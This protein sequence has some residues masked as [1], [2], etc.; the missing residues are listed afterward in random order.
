MHLSSDYNSYNPFPYTSMTFRTTEKHSKKSTIE[1][2]AS[3]AFIKQSDNNTGNFEILHQALKLK[4]F[5]VR[6][7]DRSEVFG[8]A[9]LRS[10]IRQNDFFTSE[11]E[12]L[13]A[14]GER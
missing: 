11:K 2:D 12:F 10:E 6:F 1:R 13:E 4:V 5:L 7:F 9:L 3:S 8:S 14:N